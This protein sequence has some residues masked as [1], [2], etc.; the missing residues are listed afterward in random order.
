MGL[1]ACSD[2][3]HRQFPELKSFELSRSEADMQVAVENF[4]FDFYATAARG[5]DADTRAT[6]KN[7]CVS[8]LSAS[9][10][11]A[12]VANST[13]DACRDAIAKMLK[14]DDLPAL[15]SLYNKI[16]RMTGNDPNVDI[17]LANAIWYHNGYSVTADF[18]NSIYNNFYARVAGADFNS[19]STVDDINRWCSDNTNGK[20]PTII[21]QLER[22]SAVV[23][24][25]ALYAKGDW[26]EKF[27]P[28]ET[29]TTIFH[30]TTGIQYVEM[31]KDTKDRLFYN[32]DDYQAVF[33]EMKGGDNAF[34]F[35]LPN[36]DVDI[37]EFSAG[38]FN[39]TDWRD[40]LNNGYK[41]E[42][43]LELPKFDIDCEYDMIDQLVKMGMPEYARCDAMGINE[44]LKLTALQ[45][46]S[47]KIDESGATVAAVTKI[48]GGC[49]SPGPILSSV[50]L[51]FDRPFLYFMV[52]KT[53]GAILMA[54][55]ICNL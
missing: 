5:V 9:I 55:R 45:K 37:A 10:A 7:F 8:P 39:V 6:D 24:L 19:R 41:P 54:G 53:T 16:I 29:R 26:D 36:E 35:V 14:C 25:N 15:N 49:T 32:E 4:A 28:N 52:N 33:M 23:W 43:I 48:E 34:V 17:R 46:A 51:V 13:D 40:I 21:N 38:G 31:M 44:R 1:W 18:T 2:E 20:I 12:M 3:P 47:T 30:G 11:L 27:D 42:M 50:H 22:N